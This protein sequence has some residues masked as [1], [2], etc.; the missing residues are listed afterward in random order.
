MSWDVVI[1]RFP[2]G[3]NGDFEE[4]PD[5]WE[6][7]NMF[8]QDY[9]EEEIKKLFPSIKGDKDWMTLNAQTYSIEFNIGD[10]NPISNIM[11][12]VRGGNE[13]LKAIEKVCKNFNCQALDTTESKL[14]DFNEETNEGFESWRNYKD[15]VL[16]KQNKKDE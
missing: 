6:P 10:D 3:F 4:M 12:H 14:I 8:T 15:N 16:K 5:N 13:A 1:M 2:E 9:F 7:E 11:L